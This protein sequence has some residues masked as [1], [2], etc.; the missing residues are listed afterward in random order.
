LQTEIKCTLTG[1][2]ELQKPKGSSLNYEI[3]VYVETVD[4]HLIKTCSAFFTS[5]AGRKSDLEPPAFDYGRV[6]SL[7]NIGHVDVALEAP[8]R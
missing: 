6:A 2:E 8:T 5:S 3:A 7:A 4:E 1:F